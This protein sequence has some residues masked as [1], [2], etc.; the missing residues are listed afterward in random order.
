M[1]RDAPSKAERQ[2][3]Q[4]RIVAHLK[5]FPRQRAALSYAMSA[6]G[7]D[8]DLARFKEAYNSVDDRQGYRNVQGLERAVGRVQ[9]F[10]T[11]LALDGARLAELPIGRR[12]DRDSRAKPYFDA[13][14]DARVIDGE[15]CRLLEKGQKARSA[16]E[17]EYVT[18]RAGAVH[19][20]AQVVGKTADDFIG[21]FRAWIE[22]YLD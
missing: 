19:R 1:T 2:R 14:R 18:L 7:E 3:F 21:S 20:A 10:L 13:L 8:F 15:V 12:G 5:D 22:P 9:N 16:L 11:D 17:H 4:R 6:F